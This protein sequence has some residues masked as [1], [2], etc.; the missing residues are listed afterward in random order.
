MDC[1][2][3][4]ALARARSVLL[5][6]ALAGGTVG[7][8]SDVPVQ[9][10]YHE[11]GLSCPALGQPKAPISGDTEVDH[12]FEMEGEEPLTP[13]LPKEDQTL[14]EEYGYPSPERWYEPVRREPPPIPPARPLPFYPPEPSPADAPSNTVSAPPDFVGSAAGYLEIPVGQTATL[15]VSGAKVAAPRNETIAR[16]VGTHADRVLVLGL[17]PGQTLLDVTTPEGTQVWLVR[18]R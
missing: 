18:V 12:P 8:A 17:F 9:E 2:A 7:L 1:G 6:V 11:E 10:P 4:N 16:V 3:S 15:L 5:A 13:G 14:Q